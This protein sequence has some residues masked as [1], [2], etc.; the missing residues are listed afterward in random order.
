MLYYKVDFEMCTIAQNSIRPQG[1]R[2]T[3]T[4]VRKIFGKYQARG[5][6]GGIPGLTKAKRCWKLIETVCP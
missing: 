1:A 3:F 5:G 2:I 6:S 4:Q